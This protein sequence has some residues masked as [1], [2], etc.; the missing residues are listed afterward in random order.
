MVS[1]IGELSPLKF[2][3]NI[4]RYMVIPAISLFLLFKDLIVCSQINA[5]L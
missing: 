4:D 2:I 5:T 1:L 3:V